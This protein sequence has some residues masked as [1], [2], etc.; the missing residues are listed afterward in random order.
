MNKFIAILVAVAIGVAVGIRAEKL[1]PEQHAVLEVTIFPYTQ[2]EYKDTVLLNN[3][4]HQ[5]GSLDMAMDEEYTNFLRELD[6]GFETYA[7]ANKDRK[8]IIRSAILNW[9]SSKGWKL[10]AL[11]SD[12]C[13]YVFVK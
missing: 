1:I 10:L 9:V 13:T 11:S 3:A 4:L 12:S 5:G 8:Y 2:E 7:T 6:D